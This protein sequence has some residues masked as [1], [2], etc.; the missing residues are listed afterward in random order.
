M[1]KSGAKCNMGFGRITKNTP[2]SKPSKYDRKSIQ[3][4][5]ERVKRSSHRKNKFV[6]LIKETNDVDQINFLM[7]SY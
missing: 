3:K 7:N 1:D 5:S 4:L 2:N 6:E